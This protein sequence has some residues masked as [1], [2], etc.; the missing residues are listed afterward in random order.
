MNK[1][2]GCIVSIEPACFKL[3]CRC[4]VTFHKKVEKSDLS[5]SFCK[6]VCREGE[7]TIKFMVRPSKYLFRSQKI[8]MMCLPG[9]SRLIICCVLIRYY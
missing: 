8:Q 9:K 3:S 5:I 7:V 4:F 1:E 6:R 2:M